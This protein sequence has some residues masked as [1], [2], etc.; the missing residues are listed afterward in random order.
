M[1]TTY[2]FFVEAFYAGKWYNIDYLTQGAD[3]EL[4]HQYLASISRS[5]LGLLTQ[6]IPS[7]NCV[8]FEELAETTQTLLLKEAHEAHEDYIRLENYFVLGDVKT[9]ENMLN[10]PFMNEGFITRNEAAKLEAGNDE[11]PNEIL[12]VRELLSLPEDARSEY[13]LYKWD[14]PFDSRNQLQ[15]MTDKIHDQLDAFNQSIPFRKDVPVRDLE[16]Y[17]TRILYYVT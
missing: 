11:E 3:G 16:A 14:Y 8:S 10:S 17:K 15:R 2:N 12:N 4:N 5:F 1:S 9:L 7:G 6:L 13:V